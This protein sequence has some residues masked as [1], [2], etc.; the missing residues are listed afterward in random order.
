MKLLSC[1]IENFGKLHNV[2]I[3][4]H[5]GLNTVLRENGFGKSTF[6]AFVRIMFYG[7]SGDRKSQ[8]SENERR[9][10]RPWNGSTFGGSLEFELDGSD[11]SKGKKYRITRSFGE[12]K[13]QDK[14]W[15]QDAET[16]QESR[17]F[18][19][20]IGEEIFLIDEESFR[21]TIFIG[22]NALNTELTADIN[23]KIGSV[24]EDAADMGRYDEVMEEIRNEINAITPNRR[25]GE[26]FKL[27]MQLEILRGEL[28]EKQTIQ[29]RQREIIAALDAEGRE[30][31]EKQ[32]RVT[33]LEA[34]RK[35][36]YEKELLMERQ[37]K[38]A[39][40]RKRIEE[41]D[42]RIGE[43]ERQYFQNDYYM[44]AEKA[45]EAKVTDRY[46]ALAQ[47]FSNG[48]P[49]EGFIR[50][51]DSRLEELLSLESEMNGVTPTEKSIQRRAA[52][53]LLLLSLFPMLG[54]A[55]MWFGFG[56]EGR[57]LLYTLAGCAGAL[58]FFG[59]ILWICF[60]A[61][62]PKKDYLVLEDKCHRHCAEAAE[63][64]SVYD[65]E[66]RNGEINVRKVIVSLNRLKQDV[67]EYV[68]VS[69]IIVLYRQRRQEIQQLTRDDQETVSHRYDALFTVGRSA[70]EYEDDI[71][72]LQLEMEEAQNRILVLREE[73]RHLEEKMDRLQ[74]KTDE[75]Q[76]GTEKLE[77]MEKQHAILVAT[78]D[79]LIK[80]RES[81]SKEYLNPVMA[82]FERY[83]CLLANQTKV[84]YRMDSEFRVT[85]I[86]EGQERSP[87]LLSAGFQALVEMAR[88]MAFI[89][90]M[91]QG[92][93]PFILLDDPFVNLD[94]M[95]ID[96]GL[97]F[98]KEISEKYQTLYLTCHESR[99]VH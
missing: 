77:E 5:E 13:G 2:D 31:R 3:A 82:A 96:G 43:A 68:Q 94:G 46:T 95:H 32:K 92:E 24:A 39:A 34:M 81:F 15:L 28:S 17:D 91:Y 59:V 23:A 85:L 11:D 79:Y 19:S 40:A 75:L 56:M 65:P 63:A 12:R 8:D 90:A 48:S 10:F 97:Q 93:K 35:A 49:G 67:Y 25:T 78:R 76:K 57:F 84:P 20:N 44:I 4:L 66:L 45:R 72:M 14:F 51:M 86:A 69:G 88:R 21:K 7:L 9:K 33:A 47:A 83:Y 38:I 50:K 89:D 42:K 99:T 53:I 74:Q 16:N 29:Q 6:A 80:A 27:R 18:S 64:L 26:I 41:F 58:F 55:V 1:H 54:A 61:A 98:L 62:E 71:R 30:K 22:Q 52:G 36:A 87:A 37:E 70:G 73:R 60:P